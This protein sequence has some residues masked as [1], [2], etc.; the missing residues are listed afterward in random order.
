M[1]HVLAKLVTN[2]PD[3]R[4]EKALGRNERFKLVVAFPPILYPLALRHTARFFLTAT[5]FGNAAGRAVLQCRPEG[6]AQCE[7]DFRG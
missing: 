4:G 5:A 7:D 3:L 2:S 1:L 6:R